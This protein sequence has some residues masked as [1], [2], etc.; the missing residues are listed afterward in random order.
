MPTTPYCLS[1]PFKALLT[2]FGE[3]AATMRFYSTARSPGPVERLGENLV[4]LADRE[5]DESAVIVKISGDGEFHTHKAVDEAGAVDENLDIWEFPEDEFWFFEAFRPAISR[6][7][8]EAPGYL[9]EM[10]LINLYAV[11]EAFL[12]DLLQE[13]L[14]RIPA[15]LAPRRIGPRPPTRQVRG[16]ISLKPPSTSNCAG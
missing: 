4:S 14:R 5:P 3:V 12:S 10:A 8:L 1:P 6:L 16:L 13:R 15:W 7:S 2:R 9:F 11:F